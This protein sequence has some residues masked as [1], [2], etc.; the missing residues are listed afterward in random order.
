LDQETNPL[1]IASLAG[2]VC[3]MA[4]LALQH[5]PWWRKLLSTVIVPIAVATIIRSGSRGQLLA[6]GVAL[7]V[8]WPLVSSKRNLGAW[9]ALAAAAVVLDVVG[10]RIWQHL[11]VDSSRW[12]SLQSQQDVQGRLTM[13]AELLRHATASPASLVF[14]LG[15]SSSFHYLGF[16]PHVVPAEVLGEEG[17]VGMAIYLSMIVVTGSSVWRLMT[18]LDNRSDAAARYAYGVLAALFVFEFVLTTKEGSLLS[19]TYPIAYAAILGRMVQWNRAA[20]PVTAPSEAE[21]RTQSFLNLM[22]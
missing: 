21:V 20:T 10:S 8:G 6:T 1:A 18:T 14:G 16:Y 11:G 9:L 12:S 17:L 22:R 19:S 7:L 3:V 13:A 4:M 5:S 2:T 15:N